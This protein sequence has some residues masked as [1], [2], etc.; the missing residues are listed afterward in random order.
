[1]NAIHRASMVTLLLLL[2]AVVIPHPGIPAQVERT[3]EA[4]GG[5]MPAGDQPTPPT[6]RRGPIP[7]HPPRIDPRPPDGMGRMSIV[8]SGNR[9]WCTFPDDRVVQPPL[10]IPRG[11]DLRN[12][13]YT[14]GYQFVIA[15]YE[16]SKPDETLLLY[17]SP[18]V[19]TG[20]YMPGA[21]V[22]QGGKGPPAAPEIRPRDRKP[23]QMKMYQ[24]GAGL[25]PYF[26]HTQ[27]C[28]M[29]DERFGFDLRPGT[30]DVYVAFDIMNRS[31]N[32]VHRSTGYLTG[33]DVEAGVETV[34]DG[35]IDMRG[36]G[37][38]TVDLVRAARQG[39]AGRDA[40]GR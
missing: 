16:Q 3:P 4:P 19:R 9:R 11:K 28:A 37:Q 13:V 25:V 2:A 10:K 29:V 12:L 18:V 36:G 31:G 20:S 17:E 21:K 34:V 24:S 40:G 26:Q 27:R 30:Y 23:V 14:F 8:F 22:G 32:W 39:G 5:R 15:A 7:I 1:M 38:R 6:T 35:V 33:I